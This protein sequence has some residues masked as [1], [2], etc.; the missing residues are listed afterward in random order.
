MSG[1]SM[2]TGG[3]SGGGLALVTIL[4]LTSLALAPTATAAT[5]QTLYSFPSSGRIGCYP[6]GT[7]LRDAAGALYGATS[8]CGAYD[9]GTLFK[10]A[11]PTP[12]R[13]RWTVSLLH[14]F[15]GY[16]SGGSPNADL[17]M[18]AS[19]AIYGTTEDGGWNFQGTVF[20]L[21]P[22][23][24]GTPKW[25]KDVLYFFQDVYGGRR[26]GA[27]PGAGVIMDASGELYGTTNLGGGSSV[28]GF[29]TVFKL[30][31]PASGEKKWKET[32]LHSFTGGA[33]GQN[34]FSTLATDGTGALYGTTMYGGSGKCVNPML[35][36][37]GC[38]TAFKLTPPGPGQTRWS[39]TILHTFTGGI[40]GGVPQGKLL[41]DASGALYGATYQGGS[42]KCTQ[43]V[44]GT[45]IG[46]GT[47]FKLTPPAPGQN[48]WT[49]SVLYNFKGGTD[50]A[51]PQGGVIKDAT[52]SLYGTASAG[53]VYGSGVAFKLTPP[54]PAQTKWTETVLHHFN[55]SADG[56]T[57]VGE[58]IRD[59]G[60]HLFGVTWSGGA[61]LRGT[62]FEITP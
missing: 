8:L 24:P 34:P 11:P 38:G 39:K 13:T 3:T 22:P 32:V 40:D 59:G 50:G 26:D 20:K 52:G 28:L 31:P 33:D 5:E 14:S 7:L 57:P 12:D 15:T 25:K 1:Q 46:C 35:S 30:A 21:T 53:G 6:E 51:Y 37:V 54:V 62:V 23:T 17:V 16:S 4:A 10:L 9:S 29:G 49:E 47:V 48:A 2:Q 58:I 56:D 19:G 41:L 60:G 45:V 18:D 36:T 43:L 42:G 55:I 61:Q 44:L 27:N